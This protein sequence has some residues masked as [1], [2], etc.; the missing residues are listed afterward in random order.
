MDYSLWIAL[1]GLALSCLALARAWTPPQQRELWKLI[2]RVEDLEGAHQDIRD[3]LT[4][5]AKRENMQKAR[6]VLDSER[7]NARDLEA[8]A[9]RVIQ[10]AKAGQVQEIPLDPA[11]RRRALRAQLFMKKG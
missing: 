8:E 7:S 3:R 9:L 10:E 5:R 2:G 4:Q 11:A 6:D 1:V